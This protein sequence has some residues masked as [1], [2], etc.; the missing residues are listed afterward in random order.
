M[1]SG[2]SCTYDSASLIS[3]EISH[4]K[5][6]RSLS[7]VYGETLTAFKLLM[8]STLLGLFQAPL[9]FALKGQPLTKTWMRSFSGSPVLT[10]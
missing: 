9:E 3:V 6:G 7:Q 10:D 1:F 8:P 5:V 4:L 2:S